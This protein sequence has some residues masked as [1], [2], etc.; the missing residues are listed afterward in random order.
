[1]DGGDKGPRMNLFSVFL[2]GWWWRWFTMGN[3]RGRSSKVAIME[4]QVM[5]HWKAATCEGPKWG[6]ISRDPSNSLNGERNSSNSLVVKSA[7]NRWDCGG[8]CN[9]VD[10]DEVTW[11]YKW[12]SQ[13]LMATKV[14]GLDAAGDGASWWSQCH[15]NCVTTMVAWISINCLERKKKTRYRSSATTYSHKDK[16]QWRKQ[17]DNTNARKHQVSRQCRGSILNRSWKWHHWSLGD[18]DYNKEPDCQWNTINEPSQRISES[19][20]INNARWP[21]MKEWIRYQW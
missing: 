19:L 8:N 21:T 4:Q 5:D 10:D 2:L 6:L 20:S 18:V 3:N 1:M 12:P 16:D 9:S 14:M 7:T 15:S 17:Q 13:V 11:C